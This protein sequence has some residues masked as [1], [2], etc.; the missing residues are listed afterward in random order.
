MA[1]LAPLAGVKASR[2]GLTTGELLFRCGDRAQAIYRVERGCLRLARLGADGTPV[3]L[4]VAWPGDLFAEAAL[5][6]DAYHCDAVAEGA[7]TVLAYSKA[8]VLL[9]LRAHPDL[10]L[11]FTAALTRQVQALRGRLE[12]VRLK[13]AR[14]RVL[15]FLAQAGADA[16][17]VVALDRPLIRIAAEIGLTHEAFY[18]TLSKLG[19]E[20][21]VQRVGRRA[22]RLASVG[23]AAGR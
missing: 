19:G 10:A 23:P 1:E 12:L 21:V 16:D 5:F 2:R 6:S 7:A 13:T 4:H 11:A 14:E 15:A 8:A 22:F 3:T 18:R 20:G 17:G 9:H